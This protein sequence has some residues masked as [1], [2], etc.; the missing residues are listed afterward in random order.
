MT[1]GR[2]FF[3][4]PVKNNVITNDNFRKTATDL[5]H[6]CTAGCMLNYN[7]FKNYYKMIAIDL[8]KQQALD[9]DP[10]AIRKINL[11]ANVD[12]AE[13]PFRTITKNGIAFNRKCTQA[14][15]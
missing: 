6:D 4:Q 15:R 2:N 14:I 3:R 12:R 11:N 8:S 7:Y 9:A 1:D 10:K 5:G 13:K